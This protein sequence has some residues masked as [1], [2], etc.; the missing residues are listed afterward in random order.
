MRPH[1]IG[2]SLSY[3]G[4]EP[5]DDGA[6]FHHEWEARVFAINRALLA[7]DLY[8][9]DEFRDAIERMGEEPYRT[10]S[11]YERWLHAI[12]TLLARKG[13]AGDAL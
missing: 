13:V 8:T 12:E 5:Q 3:G 2:G 6:P 4:I 1:D 11:Y 10:S 7:R 9:L